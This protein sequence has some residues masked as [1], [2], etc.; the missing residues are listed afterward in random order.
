M[1]YRSSSFTHLRRDGAKVSHKY[2]ELSSGNSP[3]GTDGQLRLRANTLYHTMAEVISWQESGYYVGERSYS[4]NS[5]A[6]VPTSI[7]TV[8][9]KRASDIAYGRLRGKLYKG[10]GALG[11]TL[12]SWKQSADMIRSNSEIIRRQAETVA[13]VHSFKKISQRIASVIFR[14]GFG[15]G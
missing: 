4:A 7:R 5:P 3:R 1:T 6:A 8:K 14:E 10:S 12:A 2:E 11:V 13:D 15:G 9:A